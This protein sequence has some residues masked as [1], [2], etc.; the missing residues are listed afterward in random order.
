M[1]QVLQF[2]ISQ[3]L[4]LTPQLQQAIRLL[5]LSSLEL[6]QEIQQQIESNPMLELLPETPDDTTVAPSW[7]YSDMQW[8]SISSRMTE[9]YA[10][11]EERFN[12]DNIYSTPRNLKEEFYWQC[13]LSPFNDRDR[14]ITHVLIDALNEDGFLTLSMQEIYN[15][16]HHNG[17][18]VTLDEIKAVR[19]Q[20]Q[21]FDPLGCF[22]ETLSETLM[23]Q[24]NQCKLKSPLVDKATLLIQADLP[25]L[26]EHN[27]RYLKKKYHLN[28]A[29]LEEIVQL[30][31]TLN[32]K[33]GSALLKNDTSYMTP[34]LYVKKHQGEWT[35]FL[36]HSANPRV[37]IHQHYAAMLHKN[38]PETEYQYLKQNLR[39]AKGFLKS[40]EN[41]HETLLNVAKFI[42]E[43][44]KKFLDHGDEA[45]RPLVL[46]EVAQ[47]LALHEST[48]SRVTTQKY[49]DTPRGLFELKYF[50]SSHVNTHLGGECSSIAI[51][52][53]IKKLIHAENRIKPLSDS[54][55]AALMS[56]QGI[57]VARRTVAKYREAMGISPSN[58]RKSF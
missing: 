42:I 50:F 40:L 55:I 3:Q 25:A 46:S 53:F 23:L 28:D 12:L 31:Q 35:V 45:M 5:Q 34:D 13:D 11:E 1:R 10:F 15:T 16:L 32:P 8:S 39:E 48:I 52:S 38:V 19:R 20:L 49:I 29:E 30:I 22:C 44:Q 9:L 27:Y 14:V 37:I 36:T 41:R 2:N 43:Y 47:A 7:D 54:K 57:Q 56:A 4:T 18:L 58:E 21:H 26:A 17:H 51:R 33:P 6:Q 24:L